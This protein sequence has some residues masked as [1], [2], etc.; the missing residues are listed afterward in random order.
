LKIDTLSHT[1]VGFGFVPKLED[2]KVVKILYD[3]DTD[4]KPDVL[5]YTLSADSWRKIDTFPPCFVHKRWADNVFVKSSVHWLAYKSPKLNNLYD[6]I[7]A[8]DLSNDQFR[9]IELPDGRGVGY[10]DIC[11]CSSVS[12]DSL[13]LFFRYREIDTDRWEFW[14]M[15]DYGVSNTWIKKFNIVLSAV[16]NPFCLMDNGDVLLVMKNGMLMSYNAKLESIRDYLIC[17]TP[18]SFRLV[19]YV[20]SLVLL[21]CKHSKVI[22]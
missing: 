2:F 5:V 17:G 6:S 16:S 12:G 22:R 10:E 21:D 13:C 14:V 20:S 3:L 8:F 15:N 11:L 9:E 4:A 18:G 19:N 7:M 1:V